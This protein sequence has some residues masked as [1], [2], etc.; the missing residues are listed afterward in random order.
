MPEPEQDLPPEPDS[1]KEKRSSGSY[2]T[3][4]CN[5]EHYEDM[6]LK[7][8]MLTVF[9][10]V[11][12]RHT[13]KLDQFLDAI[14]CLGENIKLGKDTKQSIFRAGEVIQIN[15]RNIAIGN[16]LAE[17]AVLKY[18]DKLIQTAGEPEE[19]FFLSSKRAKN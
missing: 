12:Y 11:I 17:P 8:M 7:E 10:T 14:S 15:G 2:Y 9:K 18:I 1:L 16:S 19:V 3:F 4:E 6:K 5:G 13:D